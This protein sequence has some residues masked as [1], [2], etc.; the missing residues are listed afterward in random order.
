MKPTD[1][2]RSFKKNSKERER[3]R[4][5][6]QIFSIIKNN[7]SVQQ[8]KDTAISFKIMIKSTYSWLTEMSSD[9]K[10]REKLCFCSRFERSS[11]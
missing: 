9:L 4:L 5:F 11:I 8:S 6:Q 2:Q 10:G 1:L 3:E 7:S